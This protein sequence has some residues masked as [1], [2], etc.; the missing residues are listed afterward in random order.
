[1]SELRPTL[2]T[3][4]NLAILHSSTD[5]CT[6]GGQRYAHGESAIAAGMLDAY[7]GPCGLKADLGT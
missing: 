5:G 3:L 2:A 4:R 7:L 1:M 6:A